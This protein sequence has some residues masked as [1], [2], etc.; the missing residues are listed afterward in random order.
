M[1]I[2]SKRCYTP[3]RLVKV[4]SFEELTRASN[5]F[6]NLVIFG[7]TGSSANLDAVS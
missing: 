6:E 5:S 4:G 3:P 1:K 7:L 2:E